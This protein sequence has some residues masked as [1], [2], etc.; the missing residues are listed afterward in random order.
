MGSLFAEYVCGFLYFCIVIRKGYL[1]VVLSGLFIQGYVI[2][3]QIVV[4][5]LL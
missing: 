1:C 4:Q 2:I 5:Y 3:S